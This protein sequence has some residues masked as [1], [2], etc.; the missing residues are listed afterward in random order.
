[1]ERIGAGL[2]P[3]SKF[4]AR[5]S[6]ADRHD[7]RASQT[8]RYPLRSLIW[9]A[10][11]PRPRTPGRFTDDVYQNTV[12]ALVVFQR[13]GRGYLAVRSTLAIERVITFSWIWIRSVSDRKSV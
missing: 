13:R 9:G 8:A 5:R 12:L 1:M 7:S 4:A 10:I 3:G 6:G 2:P 11:S